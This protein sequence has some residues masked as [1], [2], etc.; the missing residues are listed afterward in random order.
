[1]CQTGNLYHDDP[2]YQAWIN[3]LSKK[4]SCCPECNQEIPCGGL[5]QGAGCDCMCD[6]DDNRTCEEI[7]EEQERE[8]D[9]IHDLD[10]F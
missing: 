9:Q 7:D 2:D 8:L 1:M 10:G 6:C 3:N 5:A 4:C